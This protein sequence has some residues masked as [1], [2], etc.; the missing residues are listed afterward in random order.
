MLL[1]LKMSLFNTEYR[2]G[3]ATFWTGFNSPSESGGAREFSAARRP[4]LPGHYTALA[5][6][7]LWKEKQLVNPGDEI[8]HLDFLKSENRTAHHTD[9]YG[10]EN[11]VVRRGQEFKVK[12]TLKKPFDSNNDHLQFILSKGNKPQESKGTMIRIDIYADKSSAEKYKRTYD[13]LGFIISNE[14]TETGSD[15]TVSISSNADSLIG[16]YKIRTNFYKKEDEEKETRF[17]KEESEDEDLYLLFNPWSKDDLVYMEDE[18]EKEEYILRETGQIWVGSYFWNSGRSW[19]FGQF[20]GT[21]LRAAVYLLDKSYLSPNGHGNPILVTRAMSAMAN[22]NDNDD[23]VLSGNWSGSYDGGTSPSKWIGSVAILEEYMRTKKDVKYGQ[24]WVFSGLLTTLCRALGIPTRSV[25]NFDSAHDSDCSMT[26]DKHL[27]KETG[28]PL[29]HMDDSVWNFHVWN[30]AWMQRPDL[31]S[32]NDGWQAF[33]ATP[34]E[35]SQGRMQCGPAPVAAIKRGDVYLDYDTKF[36]FAEVNADRIMWLVGPN[37]EMTAVKE[38]TETSSIGNQISTKMVG[39]NLLND[40]TSDYKF[41]EGSKEERDAV[42]RATKFSSRKSQL[43]AIYDNK[44][45]D[46]KFDWT[47]TMYKGDIRIL[48]TIENLSDQPRKVFAR[49]IAKA[50][51][52]TGTTAEKLGDTK[53]IAA[54]PPKQ[55]ISNKL[56]LRGSLYLNTIDEDANVKFSIFAKVEETNQVFYKEQMVNI[57]KP[58]PLLKVSKENPEV[59][60]KFTL[61]IKVKNSVQVPLTDCVLHVEGPGILKT[62]EI[63][64]RRPIKPD[65]EI[66]EVLELTAKYPGQREVIVGFNSRQLTSMTSSIELDIQPKKEEEV[67]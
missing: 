38:K 51:Y 14:S 65:E 10:V 53:G 35:T 4:I 36:I 39:K 19:N 64:I 59:G 66:S 58:E 63:I 25:T 6:E 2:S 17:F 22:S 62:K 55:K 16:T 30:E 54:V 5:S 46:V 20:S 47:Y 12:I 45:D 40:I 52:Y 9:K 32:G 23:G 43:D 18:E 41:K 44:L 57:E 27:D 49:A 67:D 31:P 24:C 7:N 50:A 37:N 21:C 34:Q 33:D 26:I 1:F 61:T 11:L 56:V 8:I 13:W 60:E 48:F 42:I 3:G 28:E 29:D 15:V